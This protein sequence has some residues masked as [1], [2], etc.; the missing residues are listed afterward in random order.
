MYEAQHARRMENDL[1]HTSIL[2][3]TNTSHRIQRTSDSTC[4]PL[5]TQAWGNQP[6]PW[7]R[8]PTPQ[9]QTPHEQVLQREVNEELLDE[10]PSQKMN[11]PM[12]VPEQRVTPA[13]QR[14]ETVQFPIYTQMWGNQPP[15][16]LRPPVQR[17]EP[18]EEVSLQGEEEPTQRKEN[19]TGLPDTLKAGVE[20][21]S[22]LPM[23]DVQVHYNSS[24]PAEVQALAYTQGKEI[25]VGPGQ[26][27]HLAH[28]A[29]HVVQQK[30]G[31]VRPTLRL[32]KTAVNDDPVL[33]HE[34]DVL[35]TR[36]DDAARRVQ[37]E[38]RRGT[39]SQLGTHV[40]LHRVQRNN[41]TSK[42]EG[43]APV[44]QRLRAKVASEPE[45][46]YEPEAAADALIQQEQQGSRTRDQIIEVLR[47]LGPDVREFRSWFA[48]GW[49]VERQYDRLSGLARTMI[50]Q[51]IR[52]IYD[53][54]QILDYLAGD[55]WWYVGGYAALKWMRELGLEEVSTDDLDIAIGGE[56]EYNNLTAYLPTDLWRDHRIKVE[57]YSVQLI[58]RN[59]Y[60]KT[61][62]H[63]FASSNVL[64]PEIIIQG[65]TKEAPEEKT[66]K[67]KIT[68]GTGPM[69]L[70]AMAAM[71]AEA[72]K[73]KLGKGE[74]EAVPVKTQE[75]LEKE[76]KRQLRVKIL[77]QIGGL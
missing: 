20:H 59:E 38:T 42:Q 3:P 31:R 51:Q 39:K 49:F 11:E 64:T 1:T 32:R 12:P 22:G 29:W 36:A 56:K 77:Q 23:D 48:L 47:A 67:A 54:E 30:Q 60:E 69:G 4:L 52:S 72:A 41:T 24:K 74:A 75:Q 18:H 26:E 58:G 73:K 25:H 15:P 9:H 33:E 34:A 6:P 53:L 57:G 50:P 37:E 17:Q 70:G 5:Y 61:R 46:I 76:R 35:G 62:I 2:K 71:A 45:R 68:K 10:P 14:A 8:L 66:E 13:V 44:I 28:E 40:L 19:H 63:R 43:N 16:W 27:Q 55:R 7:L 65:Y 21:L